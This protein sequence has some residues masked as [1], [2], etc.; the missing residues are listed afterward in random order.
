MW[1]LS[2]VGAPAR[3]AIVRPTRTHTA[4]T[5]RRKPHPPCRLGKKLDP[6]RLGRRDA[7]QQF[8]FGFRIG[9]HHRALEPGALDVAGAG[10]ARSLA[11]TPGTSTCRSMRSNKGPEMRV[12]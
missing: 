5:A 8:A 7:V 3:S 9:A 11:A 10:D 2:T 12:W 6:A 4:V 1:G